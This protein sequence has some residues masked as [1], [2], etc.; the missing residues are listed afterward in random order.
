MVVKHM[1][2]EASVLIC[3]KC[4][5]QEILLTLRCWARW[6]GMHDCQNYRTVEV[7]REHTQRAQCKGLGNAHCIKYKNNR[8]EKRRH[9]TLTRESRTLIANNRENNTE[10]DRENNRLEE[11][12]DETAAKQCVCRIIGKSMRDVKDRKRTVLQNYVRAKTV[13]VLN[14]SNN[15][16]KMQLSEVI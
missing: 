2:E 14:M 10:K 9:S 1:E 7:P 3:Y 4:H 6:F 15:Q 12:D 5:R 11:K 13:I 8:R 16:I